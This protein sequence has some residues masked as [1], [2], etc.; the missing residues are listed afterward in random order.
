MLRGIN[1]INGGISR[2][3]LMALM[4]LVNLLKWKGVGSILYMIKTF[5]TLK[6][7]LV[8]EIGYNRIYIYISYNI[9]FVYNT[10]QER[11]FDVISKWKHSSIEQ[12]LNQHHRA[13]GVMGTNHW[14]CR[15]LVRGHSTAWQPN[16]PKKPSQNS[17]SSKPW[18]PSERPMQSTGCEVW[19]PKW[20]DI[21]NGMLPKETPRS[22]DKCHLDQ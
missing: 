19:F 22:L 7:H 20:K 15:H 14:E 16:S 12:L 13:M 2:L 6:L 8:D 5:N 21:T 3:H 11:S 1:P 4:S 9:I 17:N 18:R 10:T